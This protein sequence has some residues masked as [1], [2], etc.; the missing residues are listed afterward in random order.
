MATVRRAGLAAAIAATPFALAWRFAVAYRVRAGFPRPRPPRIAPSDLGLE[1]ETLS[2]PSGDAIL[3]A[4]FIPARGG[5]RGPAVALVHGWE[6]ARDRTLPLAL[7]LHAAG[8]HVLTVDIRGHGANPAEALP[9][10]AGEFGL[11]AGA[12]FDALLARP[13]VTRAAIS[14]HSM[15]GI[16]AILAAANDPRVA[17]LVATSAP[18]DP[19]RLTRETFRLA[20]LPIP[21]P[22]AY[23]LAWLT[24]RVFVRP[25]RH[26]VTAI[27]ATTAIA[28]YAGPTLLLHGDEDAVV[29]VGHVR[30]LERAARRARAGRPDAARVDAVVI[31]GGRHSWMYEHPEYRRAIATFLARELDGSLDPATAGD[32]AAAVPA[33]RIPDTADPTLVRAPAV[34]G[35]QAAIAER[36]LPDEEPPVPDDR[37]DPLALAKPLER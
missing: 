19:W 18:A 37:F 29:P 30:R 6:S 33:T 34:L 35:T 20:R 9:M 17:A 22:V 27:S 25:R 21:D 26:A 13:E 2:V 31:A 4:W 7:V 10:T 28:R 11:D 5:R 36:A 24:T 32:I 16:G 8:F 1:Y 15:G 3:P 14:G 23:P 12:A